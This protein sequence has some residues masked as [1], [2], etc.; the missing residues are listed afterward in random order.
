M[1][2]FNDPL[3]KRTRDLPAC[4]A[5]PQPTATPRALLNTV[6]PKIKKKPPLNRRFSSS[7]CQIYAFLVSGDFNASSTLAGPLRKLNQKLRQYCNREQERL[8]V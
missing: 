3:G 1:K 4:S 8:K 5:V 2:I 7:I 6:H